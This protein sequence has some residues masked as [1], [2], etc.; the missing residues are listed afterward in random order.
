ML[1]L[2]DRQL[3]DDA[4]DARRQH[5]A[6]VGFGLSGNADGARMVLARRRDDGDG[7]QGSLGLF[8]FG[9]RRLRL[10]RV[11]RLGLLASAALALSAAALPTDEN[12]PV[13]IQAAKPMSTT[14]AASL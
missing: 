1:A 5:G 11:R 12:S 2:L 7:A 4:G 9:F 6:L 3:V 10:A 14:T 13:P 8:G